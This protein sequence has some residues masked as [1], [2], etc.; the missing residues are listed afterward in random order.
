M[1]IVETPTFTKR[2]VT[3]LSDEEY[4]ELQS[5]LIERPDRGAVIPGTKGLRKLRFGTTGRGKRGGGRLIYYW[6]VNDELLYMV[7][8]YPKGEISDLTK[9][10]LKILAKQVE[11]FIDER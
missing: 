2:I 7:Y 6:L 10:Q 1:V 4:R 11:E 3:I 9:N 5:S 8:A